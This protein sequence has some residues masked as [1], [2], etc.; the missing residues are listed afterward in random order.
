MSPMD[1]NQSGSRAVEGGATIDDFYRNLKR[2]DYRVE[3]QN[4]R[5]EIAQHG[6]LFHVL[7]EL[8]AI[9]AERSLGTILEVGAGSAVNLE[10]VRERITARQFVACDVAQDPGNYSA[11]IEFRKAP[12]GN[13][14]RAFAPSSVSV[15]LFMEVIEHLWDPDGALESIWGIL[16]EDGRAIVTTPNLSSALNR[17]GLLVGLQ[18]IGTEVSTRRI[19]G[20]P[21]GGS[22][23]GH[24]RVFTLRSLVEI[25]RASGFDVLRAYTAPSQYC[26]TDSSLAGPLRAIDRGASRVSR[27]FG[28]R[29]IV[30]LRKPRH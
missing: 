18:P 29:S 19:F 20:R 5:D 1:S 12:V 25:C 30:V 13:L 10:L 15:V 14:D 22:V 6:V 26:G 23:V 2:P 16:E 21:G 11:A 3:A 8:S 9:A 24:I 7:Q 27:S 28:S 4:K 17:L